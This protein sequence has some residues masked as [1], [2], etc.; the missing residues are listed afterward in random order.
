MSFERPCDAA[1][2]R[3]AIACLDLTAL[4]ADDDA[5]GARRLAERGREAGVAALCLRPAFVADVKPLLAGAD[6]RLATV[7]NFPDGADDIADAAE[8]VKAAFAAGADE[9]DV[10]APIEAVLAGDVGLVGELVE[11][12]VAERPAGRT[13]KLILETGRLEDPAVITAA[14][15]AAVMAGVD[16]LKTS[17]GKTE[18][19]ATPEAATTLLQVIAEAGGR[20]GLKV[21]GG[22]R[23]P[24]QAAGYLALADERMGAGWATPVTF[25]IGASSLLDGLL[26]RL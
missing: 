1:T 7:A 15:R 14:A 4:G 9:V 10:V 6:V 22:V 11:L 3:R 16:M 5:A 2:A 8:E 26:G 21:S 25:R 24:E 13:L 19:G 23:T 20:V 18:P 12:C 17:T